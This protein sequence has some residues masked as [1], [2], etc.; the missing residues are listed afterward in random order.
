MTM[1]TTRCASRR[2]RRGMTR[3]RETPRADLEVTMGG[4]TIGY[5]TH[6]TDEE[7]G[8]ILGRAAG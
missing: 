6:S 7:H 3:N 1:A 8:A 2:R 4:H 5:I